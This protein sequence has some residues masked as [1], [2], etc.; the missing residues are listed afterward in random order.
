V[1]VTSAGNRGTNPETGLITYSGITSPGNSPSAITVGAVRHRNTA[2]RLDDEIARFSSRGPT[3][4]DGLAKPDVL[5]PGQGLTAISTTGSSLWR[6]GR[7]AAD[8]EPYIKLSGTSMASAVATGVVAHVIEANRRDEG[9]GARLTPNTVKA[10]LEY[11]A[12]A[13]P[14]D[15]PSTPAALEQGA[16]ALNAVGAM[17]LARA[18]DPNVKRKYWWI[19]Y[20]FVPI[21]QI[22]GQAFP[23]VQHIVWGDHLVWG[24]SVLW[25]QWAWDDHIVW[26]D[27]IVWSESIFEGTSLVEDSFSAWSTAVWGGDV[28]LKSS[29]L[30]WGTDDHIVWGEDDDHIVWGEDDDHIVWGSSFDDHIIWGN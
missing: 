7:F 11:T 27:N 29:H 20:P 16:G 4:Y 28:T 25:S 13:L 14:D 12:I 19:E 23:W 5:A 21:S 24:D 8:V 9:P 18:I 17:T 15:D 6:D 30:V 2:D 26:G 10:A 22:A 3:W 1:V